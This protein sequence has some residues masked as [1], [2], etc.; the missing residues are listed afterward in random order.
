MTSTPSSFIKSAVNE[1]M[2]KNP[3]DAL[4]ICLE[5]DNILITGMAEE[6][7]FNEAIVFA[8]KFQL[9]ADL[10]YCSDTI[11][12]IIDMVQKAVDDP[13]YFILGL[14]VDV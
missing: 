13:Y 4:K 3:E 7:I 2:E 10:K 11:E 6:L 12:Q 8:D 5:I 1:I 14:L 9:I